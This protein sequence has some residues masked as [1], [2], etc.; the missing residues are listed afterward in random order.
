M[1]GGGL[2][3]G[4]GGPGRAHAGHHGAVAGD[5]HPHRLAALAGAAQHARLRQPQLR[6]ERPRGAAACLR[7]RRRQPEADVHPLH[8]ARQPQLPGGDPVQPSG[9]DAAGQG[10]STGSDWCS[11]S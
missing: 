6:T 2:A 4:V 7:G 8:V 11:T 10:V 1:P 9:A 5:R 3:N